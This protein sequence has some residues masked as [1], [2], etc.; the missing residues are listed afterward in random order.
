MKAALS[1]KADAAALATHAGSLQALESAMQ[2]AE[3]RLA[4]LTASHET[5]M[6]EAQG[7]IV[8]ATRAA[9]EARAAVVAAASLASLRESTAASAAEVHTL[10]HELDGV[11]KALADVHTMMDAKADIASVNAVLETK[12]NKA[13]VS[14]ALANKV[15]HTARTRRGR[16]I[17]MQC[18]HTGHARVCARYAVRYCVSP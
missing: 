9:N 1:V 14:Q 13:T 17:P 16:R 8:A 3:S 6:R 2:A 18:K 11:R 10:Q 15:C 5:F 12:A 4:N 7:G